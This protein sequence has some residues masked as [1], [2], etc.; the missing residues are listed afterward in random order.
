MG[1][2]STF[3][4]KGFEHAALNFQKLARFAKLHDL[5]SIEH[6]LKKH[7]DNIDKRVAATHNF[8]RVHDRLKTMGNG[9]EG[10]IL[11]KPLSQ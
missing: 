5:T 2:L 8:I 1:L 4:H 7:E 3:V 6:H 9:Q 10:H 11:S